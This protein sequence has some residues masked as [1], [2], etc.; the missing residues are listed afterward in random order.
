MNCNRTLIS[1][2]KCCFTLVETVMVLTICAMIF[3]GLMEAVAVTQVLCQSGASQ[4]SVQERA[5]IIFRSIESDLSQSLVS[6][7]ENQRIPFFI[8]NSEEQFPTFITS[9]G[10]TSSDYPANYIQIGYDVASVRKNG[11]TIKRVDD[12]SKSEQF[13][14]RKVVRFKTS[15]RWGFYDAED[16][17]WVKFH[18]GRSTGFRGIVDGVSVEKGEK[19]TFTFYQFSAAEDGK[20]NLICMKP[21]L[22]FKL[23]AYVDIKLT[24]YDASIGYSQKHKQTLVKRIALPHSLE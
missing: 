12:E 7:V 14:K 13:F 23:P 16:D 2:T 4:I 18:G 11:V 1:S 22:H 24:L 15:D 20:R 19:M 6:D 9:S 5:R 3:A 8:E 10:Q 17:S 21:G